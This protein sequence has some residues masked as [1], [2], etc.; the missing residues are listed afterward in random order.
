VTQLLERAH[1]KKLNRIL[2]KDADPL[3]ADYYINMT[4]FE[5]VGFI[6]SH[7]VLIDGGVDLEFFP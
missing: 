5:Q 2:L 1:N 7:Y 3:L 4:T 6:I